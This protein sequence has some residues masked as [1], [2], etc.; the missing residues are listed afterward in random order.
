MVSIVYVINLHPFPHSSGLI[1]DHSK[2]FID[3]QEMMKKK[4]ALCLRKN[5]KLNSLYSFPDIPVSPGS[6]IKLMLSAK[7]YCTLCKCREY[8]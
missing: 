2:S 1:C 6:I 3:S 5:N 4:E 8:S 7:Q